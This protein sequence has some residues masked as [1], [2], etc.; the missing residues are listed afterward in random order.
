MTET[1]NTSLLT[2]KQLDD[3][4]TENCYADNYGIGDRNI[5]EGYGLDNFG[6]LYVWYYKERGERENVN[7]FQTEKEAVDFAFKKITS[8]KFAKSHMVGFINDKQSENEFL[9]ELRN[10]N[11]EFWKDEIPYYG[12][13]KLTTRVFVL[14]CDIKKVLDLHNK[15]G[16]V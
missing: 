16:K 8:D 4:M 14:G 10:R 11:V 13:E 9:T 3:W 15:Y 6:S 2:V 5:H 7:Y 1:S 12:L